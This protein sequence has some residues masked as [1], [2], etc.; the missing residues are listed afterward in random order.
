MRA[1][2]DESYNAEKFFVAAAAATKQQWTTVETHVD[3]LRAQVL[4]DHGLP[5][6]VEFHAVEMF[7][8]R[9]EWSPMR[10]KHTEVSGIAKAL[11]EIAQDAGVRYFIRGVDIT[12]LNRRYAFPR[13]P[14]S[15]CLEHVLQHLEKCAAFHQLPAGSV[16]L[17]ADD[18]DLRDE[19]QT[20]FE[21]YQTRGAGSWFR[22]NNLEHLQAP[23]EFRDSREY[24]G[25]QVVDFVAYLYRRRAVV[26]ERHPKAQKSMERLMEIVDAGTVAGS[27]I[28]I[29]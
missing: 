8:G 18:V 5:A 16:Q 29:P 25:L 19:L 9:R 21:G 6:D 14:H 12:A 13:H 23:I 28:W 10:G 26:I 11:L 4:R 7:G 27:G 24:A 15:V 17:V 3:V 22:S 1:Y 20:Q 2:L